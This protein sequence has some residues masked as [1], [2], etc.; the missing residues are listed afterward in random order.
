MQCCLD[1]KVLWVLTIFTGEYFVIIWSEKMR[2]ILSLFLF[3]LSFSLFSLFSLSL[4]SLLSPFRSE[5]KKEEKK[6]SVA[7]ESLKEKHW[8]KSQEKNL[9]EKRNIVFDAF[10]Q[11]AII[12]PFRVHLNTCFFR[13][14]LKKKERNWKKKALD[15]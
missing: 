3:S 15:K 2:F 14:K 11:E 9:F 12:D 13:V 8:K 7:S 6:S 1:C 5:R 10:R 4:S